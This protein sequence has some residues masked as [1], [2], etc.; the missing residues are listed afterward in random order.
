M[1]SWRLFDL[2]FNVNIPY[3]GTGDE[4]RE[5]GYIQPLG[6]THFSVPHVSSVDIDDIGED[7]EGVKKKFR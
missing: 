1:D 3:N 4:L 5:K 2:R 7:L 6:L